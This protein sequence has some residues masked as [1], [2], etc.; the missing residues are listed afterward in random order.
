[1]VLR[2]IPDV[3]IVVAGS[4]PEL[5]GGWRSNLS[6]IQSYRRRIDRFVTA[7]DLTARVHF[8]GVRDDVP[9]LLAASDLLAFPSVV[10][11]FARPIIEAGAMAK[12]V[13][14]SELAGPDELVVHSETGLLVPAGDPSALADAI[15]RVLSDSGLSRAM[16][17][18]GYERARALYNA[19][20]NAAETIAL[21]DELLPQAGMR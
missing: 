16:A 20:I 2:H 7:H 12:P 4:V 8:V 14:A 10:P 3:H 17:E 18:A 1:M 9:Q 6:R 21:Y 13:V 5:N 15:L 19:E 11:H